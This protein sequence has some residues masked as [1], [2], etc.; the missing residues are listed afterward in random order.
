MFTPQHPRKKS[1]AAWNAVALFCICLVGLSCSSRQKAVRVGGYEIDSVV[2]DSTLALTTAEGAPRC[3]LSLHLHYL[4]EEKANKM[5][6]T[7]LRAGVL[8][9]DYFSLSREKLS[10][11]ALVDSFAGRY[12]QEYLD[13]YGPLY[14]AD[15]EHASSY[16][17][18]YQVHSRFEE[19]D[20]D[21]LNYFTEVYTYGGGMHGIKQTLVLNID[22]RKG[23]IIRLEDLFEEDAA[24]KL[25][26]LIT[27]QFCQQ[28][29]VKSLEELREKGLFV[30]TDVYAS[31]NFVLS[32][33]SL[34]F[35]YGEDEIAP[36]D[37]G[38]F[39]I[40]ISK[41]DLKGLLK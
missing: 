20:D 9:P 4:K 1:A 29:K 35:I 34:T 31:G 24:Q 27:E 15:Q 22:T 33:K 19:G 40:E 23:N 36:H 28:L 6:D 13:E 26:E 12:L 2:L 14:R 3:K 11:K 5:N 41:K 10:V 32:K 7:L 37:Q 18:E 30:N 16:N 38:A 39:R 25:A 8:T 21:I 17:V